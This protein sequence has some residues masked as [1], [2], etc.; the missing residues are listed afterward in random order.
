[1]P[2]YQYRAVDPAG[3]IT[4]GAI[5]GDSVAAVR[6]TLK[7]QD[8]LPIEINLVEGLVLKGLPSFK[9]KKQISGEALS[10][11]CRQLSVI[12]MSG[13][14]VLKGLEI[15]G[16]QTSDKNLK[17]E[18]NRIYLEVQKGKT[19]AEAMDSRD[20]LMP[21]LLISMVA[22]GEASGN[23]D[24]VL[25]SMSIFYE[26][27]HRIRQKIKSA[28]VYPV[29]MAVMAVGL[30]VFFFNFLLPQLVSLITSNGGQLPLLTRIVIA[31]SAFTSRYFLLITAVSAG[32]LIIFSIYLKTPG[33][34]LNRDKLIFKVPLL[35]EVIR[36]VT[37]MRFSRT[38]HILIKSGLPLLQGLEYVKQ[39]VNNA[40]AEKAV[41]YAIEG[42]QRGESLAVNLAKAKYFDPMATQ[43]FA[44]GEETGELEQILEEMADY[45]NHES[46]AGFERLLALVE[47]LML[48]IIGGIVSTVII[49]VMLPMMDMVSNIKR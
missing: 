3:E 46:D 42:L 21:K 23:L 29:V 34:R 5:S 13:V 24:V 19:I 22:T 32:I 27:D 49:S 28:A 39:N 18:I 38:T 8:L 1:M 17:K 31:I 25:R 2:D 37:T 11:F 33:G 41:D 12:I 45:Y 43:M 48:I 20:T 47:P 26:K 30:M 6:Q 4:S 16:E 14:N 36:A 10:N 35:G 7:G 44:I 40:L 15:L 9:F